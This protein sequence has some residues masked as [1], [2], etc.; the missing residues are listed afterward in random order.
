MISM[1][2]SEAATRL[3]MNYQEADVTFTGCSTD[4]RTLQ[5][6][7][8][9]IA[10]QGEKFDGHHFIDVAIGNGAAA[11]LVDREIDNIG[12]PVLKVK[13]TRTAMA[14]LAG[15]WRSD[16]ALPLVAVTGSNGKTTVKE[17]LRAILGQRVPVLATQGNLNN[18][19]GVPLTLFRLGPEH[20]YAII[21]MGA[22]HAGEIAALCDIAKPGVGVITQCAPA[23]LEGFGSIEGVAR[24]KSEIYTGLVNGGTAIINADDNYAGFWRGVAQPLRQISFGLDNPA[25]VSAS[26]ITIDPS[27][28]DTRFELKTPAG[29]I[30]ITLPLPGR[31]NVMNALAATA[32]CLAIGIPLQDIRDGLAAMERVKGRLQK[33]TSPEGATIFDDT[34]N[35]NPTSLKAGVHVLMSCSGKHWLV[36]GDMGELGSQ[37]N[38]LHREAGEMA[39]EQGIE[40]VYALGDATRHTVEGFGRGAMHCSNIDEL[41]GKLK[42]ELAN[43]VNVLVKGSRFMAMER[44]IKALMEK[45]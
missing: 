36:V 12:L 15:S 25:D 20:R 16:F 39:R 31:H 35:A 1:T 27:T 4:S 7:N 42:P 2:L 14:T 26:D 44:V 21:E 18:D 9:F 45:H 10:L 11:A 30:R 33:L 6:G 13:N 24:A 22:N 41:I 29:S 32:C 28:T 3:G 23:H 40:R 19:I 38:L 37:T 43:G 8:L 17:M 5:A 34:Y